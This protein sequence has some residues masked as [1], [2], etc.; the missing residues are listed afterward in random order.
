M[1]VHRGISFTRDAVLMLIRL[2][3]LLFMEVS[4]MQLEVVAS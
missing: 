4:Y 3:L 1:Q 2:M